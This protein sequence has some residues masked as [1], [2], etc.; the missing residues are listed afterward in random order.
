MSSLSNRIQITFCQSCKH[1]IVATTVI[2]E[3]GTV[4][5]YDSI[6]RYLDRDSLTTIENCFTRNGEVPQ[7]K[8][9]QCRKQ[10]GTKD[11]GVYAI[12]FAVASS[13]GL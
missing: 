5:V 6:F 7:V 12:V 2:S 8:M 4:K 11:C 13:N 9:A 10:E 3:C 1:W